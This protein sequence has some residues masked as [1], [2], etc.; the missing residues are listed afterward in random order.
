MTIQSIRNLQVLCQASLALA[1]V[2]L[3]LAFALNLVEHRQ[4]INTLLAAAVA[5][6]GFGGLLALIIGRLKCPV[7]HFTFVGKHSRKLFTRTCRNCGRRA[8]D[9]A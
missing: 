3:L 2:L 4:S 8:G 7:C 9:T 6:V 5:S 1:P